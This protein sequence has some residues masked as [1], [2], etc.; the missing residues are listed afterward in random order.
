MKNNN[1]FITIKKELRGILRDKKYLSAGLRDIT[2]LCLRFAL[3]DAIFPNEKPT[4]I[5]DDPFVN[6]D[7]KNIKGGLELL[8]K[9]ANDK[10]IIYFVCHSSRT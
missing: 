5:L 7:D 3:I 8:N 6:L 10:Q 2:D 4:I 9:I 1:I